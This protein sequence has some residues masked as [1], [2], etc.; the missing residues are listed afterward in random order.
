MLSD[1]RCYATLPTANLDRLRRFYEGVLGFT[2][3]RVSPAGV[4]YRTGDGLFAITRSDGR[5]SGSH[6][7]LAFLVPD[8]AAEVAD[9]RARGVRFEEYGLSGFTT[10]DGIASIGTGRAAWFKDPAGNLVGIIQ[11]D[12]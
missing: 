5:A 7:Q 4:Y 9:L 6:T 10:V 11:F 12:A 3:E 2:P 8:L 1:H